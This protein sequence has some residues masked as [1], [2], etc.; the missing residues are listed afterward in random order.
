M[1]IERLNSSTILLY[2]VVR[3]STSFSITIKR[4]EKI[5]LLVFSC[6]ST[7]SQ[8]GH[9]LLGMIEREKRSQINIV[10]YVFSRCKLHRVYNSVE[11]VQL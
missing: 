5:V 2:Y 1:Q 9:V 11:I 7:C 10:G 6:K 4:N 8:N 3:Y